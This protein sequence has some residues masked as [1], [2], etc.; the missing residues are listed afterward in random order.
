VSVRSTRDVVGAI[1]GMGLVWAAFFLTG[2]RWGLA[3]A[4][5]LVYEGWTLANRTP[6]D[7]ISEII[8]AFARRQLLVPWLF[9]VSFGI[10]VATGYIHDPYV[11]AAL[12]LL[13]GH[14]FFTLDEVKPPWPD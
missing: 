14:F 2:L 8:R 6:H 12:A 5:L 11:I 9:G 10:G 4:A 3:L 13:Q 7:T 1:M